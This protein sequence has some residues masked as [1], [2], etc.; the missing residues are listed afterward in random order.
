MREFI[1]RQRYH[2]IRPIDSS[3]FI[4]LVKDEN[5][6]RFALWL[7]NENGPVE[8]IWLN[9]RDTTWKVHRWSWQLPGLDGGAFFAVG[10]RTLQ[11]D[12][13]QEKWQDRLS[14]PGMPELRLGESRVEIRKTVYDVAPISA[15]PG[16]TD[17]EVTE[18]IEAWQYCPGANT[19]FVISRFWFDVEMLRQSNLNSEV[20]ET[21]QHRYYRSSAR[22]SR[23][24]SATY[25]YHP[26]DRTAAAVCYRLSEGRVKM[27][28]IW[29]LDPR[30]YS[31]RGLNPNSIMPRA[32]LSA[33]RLNWRDAS[34]DAIEESG[35]DDIDEDEFLPLNIAM[36]SSGTKTLEV[37]QNTLKVDG[38]TFPNDREDLLTNC[39]YSED[40]CCA[41]FFTRY[42]NQ[43]GQ[44]VVV[45]DRD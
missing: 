2:A 31:S 20:L 40:G 26:E 10:H 34:L 3:R 28:L 5:H 37:Y 17:F 36:D 18:A 44:R 32:L 29:L 4:G 42:S 7:A 16:E 13:A 6:L 14:L 1:L 35:L 19:L 43:D 27:K 23:A 21:L 9:P 33:M 38:A 39:A 41:W 22:H 12:E 25:G 11:W 8:R 45:I 24:A 30:A 15:L